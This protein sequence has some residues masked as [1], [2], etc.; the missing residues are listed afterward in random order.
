MHSYSFQTIAGGSNCYLVKTSQGFILIDA[1]FDARRKVV[2]E[3]LIRSG[4]QPGKLLVIILTHGDI[5][6]VAN[7]LF[8]REKYGVKIGMHADDVG[9][10]EFGDQRWNRKIPPD[11]ITSFGKFV[12]AFFGK[13]PIRFDL[14]KPDIHFQDGED[15]SLYGFP[16]QIVHIPG[17]SKGSI[18]VITTDGN[19]FCGDLFFNF[20]R[21]DFHFMIDNAQAARDSLQKIKTQNV[22]M[23]YP[24]HGRPFTIEKIINK[25]P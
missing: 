5:D 10:V 9:M 1:G 25:I 22:K 20:I 23:I 7:A 12:R 19:L 17:H 15:L 8:L 21:P 18:G 14:F 6:H 13:T 16:A 4:C 24:G 3:S 11:R 2:D